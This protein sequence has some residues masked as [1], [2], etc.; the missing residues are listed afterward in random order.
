[1]LNLPFRRVLLIR[2][3]LLTL[4]FIG[5]SAMAG[6]EDFKQQIMVEATKQSGDGIEKSMYYRGDVKISQGSLVIDADEV[7]VIAKDGV[8]KEIFIA[9]GT[10]ASYEQTMDDGSHIKALAN[11]IK[12]TV[13]NRTLTLV[14][15][16]EL[17]QNSSRVQGESILF[18][19]ENEQLNAEGNENTGDRVTTIFQPEKQDSNQEQ[20]NANP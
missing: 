11:E 8:G 9:R 4:A 19:M 5:F 10:P 16:A 7:D 6:K 1:M 14:G 2:L 20:S 13:A 3:L 18:D 17:H 12:Y 15:N